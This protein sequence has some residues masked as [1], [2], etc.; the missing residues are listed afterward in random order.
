MRLTIKLQLAAAFGLLILLLVGGNLF[1]MRELNNAQDTLEGVLAAPVKRMELAQEINIRLLNIVR[2]EKNM[3]LSD[4]IVEV[5][6]FEASIQKEKATVEGLLDKAKSL[7][8]A[9]GKPRWLALE[10]AYNTMAEVHTR[11]FAL[12]VETRTWKPRP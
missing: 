8:S 4:D 11:V 12:A 9:E 6:K 3:V 2:A 5:R 10:A 1:A 7:A